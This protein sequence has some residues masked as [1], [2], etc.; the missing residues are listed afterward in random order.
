ME[1]EVFKI[2]NPCSLDYGA[3][4]RHLKMFGRFIK[5][6]I[7]IDF[8]FGCVMTLLTIRLLL[9]IAHVIAKRQEV[10]VN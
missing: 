9:I 1:S 3:V 5:P 10:I 4:G 8:L 7:S 6:E 2:D